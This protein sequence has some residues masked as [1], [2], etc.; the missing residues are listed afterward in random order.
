MKDDGLVEVVCF[1][2]EADAF[3]ERHERVLDRGRAFRLFMLR[4]DGQSLWFG[5]FRDW[6]NFMATCLISLP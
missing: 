1:F 6:S 5:P 4:F 2:E 3:L